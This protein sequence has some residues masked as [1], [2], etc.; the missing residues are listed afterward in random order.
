MGTEN[1]KYSALTEKVIGAFYDVAYELG[2][3]FLESVYQRALL[4]RLRELGLAA[5]SEVCVPVWYHAEPVGDFRADIVVE[6]KLLLELKAVERLI[7]AHDAQVLHYLKATDF[8]V[9]L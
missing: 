6:K 8:E 7:S 5:E 2:D 3:G 1:L 4:I 9:A